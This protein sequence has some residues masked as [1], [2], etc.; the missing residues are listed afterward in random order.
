MLEKFMEDCLLCIRAHT[1]AEGEYEEE[2]AAEKMHSELTTTA[3]THS[4]ALLR[5]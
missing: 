3:I 1:G 4:P 2:G 5:R